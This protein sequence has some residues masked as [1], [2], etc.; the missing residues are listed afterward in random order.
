MANGSGDE[1]RFTRGDAETIARM[2]VKQDQTHVAIE[3]MSDT[4][5]GFVMS[6]DACHKDMNTEIRKNTG[7]RNISVS[8]YRWVL[9]VV[10]GSAVLGIVAKVLDFI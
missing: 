8:V 4:L 9:G 3:K 10:T 6:A 5:T 2:A 7:F 1:A